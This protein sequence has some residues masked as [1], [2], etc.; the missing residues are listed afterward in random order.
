VTE[1]TFV[2]PMRKW[3]RG[4]ADYAQRW[5]SVISPKPEQGTLDRYWLSCGYNRRWINLL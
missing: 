1:V 5:R 4:Y 2:A 3:L